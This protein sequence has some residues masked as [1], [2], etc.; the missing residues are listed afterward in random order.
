MTRTGSR[1]IDS[2]AY[3]DAERRLARLL[4]TDREV[5]LL[6]GE[7][8]LLLEATARGLGG[9]GV[10][11]LNLVSGPYGE[12]IG[13]WLAAG[14]AEVEQLAV[15]LDSSLDVDA[16]RA[17]LAHRPVDVVSV[18]HAEAATGV[19]NPL[20][21]IAAAV[22][23]AGAVIVV[24]AVA[25]IGAEPLRIDAWDLDLVM[26]G[27]Q[28]AL[29]GPAGVS[30]LV[31]SERGWA[32]IARNP[33]APRG[34]ILSLLD[35]KER[36]IDAGRRRIPGYAHEHEMRALIDALE[37]LDGD[38]GLWR[39]IDRHQRA[40]AAGRAGASAL[41]LEPWIPR[42][43][44]AAS[45]V[46]LVRPPRD[47]TVAA[48]LDASARYLDGG[49]PGLLTAAPGP[50]AELAIR[51]NHTGEGARPEPVLAAITALAGGLRRLGMCADVSR[52]L[53][54][55]ERALFDSGP[56]HGPAPQ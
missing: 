7:A 42:E 37:E 35:W 34:S 18:V 30:A 6:Q 43:R 52:A 16:V 48:V 14:G 10:R 3:A 5:T 4:D 56:D 49:F 15:E 44:D 38:V 40:R 23:E 26:I 50:L 51:I 55:A 17:A 41:G 36:W 29:A 9:P 12:V 13:D 47:S 45:V 19:V 24:D 11:T 39:L 53:A 1:P 22:H 2:A 21:E 28:K 46:T 54:A 20:E 32:Q 8:I 25:S 31:A 33:S 27:P